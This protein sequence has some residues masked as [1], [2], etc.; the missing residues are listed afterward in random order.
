MAWWVWGIVGLIAL[1]AEL[2]T[3]TGFYLAGFGAGALVVAALVALGLEAP[4]WLELLLFAG[5]SVAA[6]FG[7]RAV[8]GGPSQDGKRDLADLVGDE[9]VVAEDLAPGG[10]GQV[11]H[12]GTVW[13]ARNAGASTL[14]RGARVR[15]ESVEGVT[16]VLRG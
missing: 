7:S 2:A 6:V 3:P 12:R 4:F 1:G 13:R 16:L 10:V 11:E 8:L 14:A 15:V 5:V 9:V